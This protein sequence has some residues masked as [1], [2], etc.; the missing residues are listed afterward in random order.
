VRVSLRPDPSKGVFETMLVLDGLPVELEAHLER[1]A[2]SVA[3][4]YGKRLP[5]STRRTVLGEAAGRRHG[6]LRVDVAPGADGRLAVRAVTAE[7]D[8]AI[9]FPAAA[10]AARLRSVTVAGGLGPH[11]WADRRLLDD[12]EANLPPGELPL[13]L[14]ADGS[15]L[16]VSRASV[17]RVRGERIETP[18]LDGRILPSIARRQVLAAASAEG[19]DVGE[20]RLTL[21]DLLDGEEAF[22]SG[23]VRGV[24][25]VASIDGVEMPPGGELSSRA[26]GALRRRWLGASRAAG[27]AAGAGA[28]PAGPRVR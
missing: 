19:I 20:T 5:P 3:G 15:V 8:P 24:E 9:V 14:D 1:L 12:A 27:A 10:H 7:V 18:P 13:L 2:E 11:K 16:E 26:A 6:K 17:F 22:L 23:S 28:R 4:L 25:P 21:A